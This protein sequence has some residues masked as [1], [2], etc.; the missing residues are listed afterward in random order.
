M[1]GKRLSKPAEQA[2]L[3]AS[4]EIGC[5]GVT[6]EPPRRPCREATR[7]APIVPSEALSALGA[8]LPEKLF[9][10]TSSWSFPGWAGIVYA[11]A[12]SEAE[13]ARAGLSAYAAH[14]LMR[15]V[16]IDRTFYAP[17]SE[18]AYAAYARQVSRVRRDFQFLVKAPMAVT[19]PRLRDETGRWTDNPLF[20]DARFAVREFIEPASAG[21]GRHCGPLVFQFPPLGPRWV[22]DSLALFD[23]L[24]EFLL[25]VREASPAAAER[26]L[27]VE[28]RDPELLDSHYLAALCAGGAAPCLAIHAR[29]PPLTEQLDLWRAVAAAPLIVRWSLHSG[30]A[31]EQARARYAPFDRLIDED[32]ESRHALAVAVD[33]ALAHDRAA[34]IIVNNKAEGS[35]PLSIEALAALIAHRRHAA[36]HGTSGLVRSP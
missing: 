10:G 29:M 8:A 24:T 17:L 15:A 16:G 4:E 30:L 18:A 21:L 25:A 14:P 2:R 11:S 7:V 26:C 6:R 20:L 9:F 32:P 3:F 12:A 34:I 33:E 13:L 22:R 23:R 36:T 27:A 19:A 31:Y 35:A 28:L 1:P 5:A